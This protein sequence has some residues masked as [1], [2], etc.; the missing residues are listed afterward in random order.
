MI[1]RVPVGND[2]GGTTYLTEN[3]CDVDSSAEAAQ[4][5]ADG[6]HQ[7]NED[8][9]PIVS[10]RNTFHASRYVFEITEWP[11]PAG[12]S[13][14][15]DCMY[16]TDPGRFTKW[17]SGGGAA[18]YTSLASFQAATGQEPNGRQTTDCSFQGTPTPTPTAT[19]TRTPTPP[20]AS[21][22][23]TGGPVGGIAELPEVAQ[24]PGRQSDSPPQMHIAPT[25]AVA[26][27]LVTIT[28]GAWYAGRRWLR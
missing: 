19:P 20:T 7:T 13:F 15:Y 10:R 28:A 12:E 26:V 5:G 1:T 14:D 18:Y 11:R 22:G 4:G 9:S 27:V 6:I 23:P 21:P 2:G 8:L 16:T 3:V 24:A 17:G 25:T